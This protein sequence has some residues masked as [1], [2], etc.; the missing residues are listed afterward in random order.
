MITRFDR[1]DGTISYRL[2]DAR[3]HRTNGPA[4]IWEERTWH[5]CLYGKSHRYY[6]PAS[7]MGFWYIHGDDI[8]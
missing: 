3:L 8:K 4:K 7:W 1:A 2:D 5:W 6:G